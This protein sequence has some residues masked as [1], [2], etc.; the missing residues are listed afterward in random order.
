M[1]AIPVLGQPGLHGEVICQ[2]GREEGRRLG[3]GGKIGRREVDLGIMAQIL[4]PEKPK[5][6]SQMRD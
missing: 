2:G 1:P 6:A 3:E 4:A 5:Q